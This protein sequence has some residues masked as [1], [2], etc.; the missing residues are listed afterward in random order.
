MPDCLPS[1]RRRYAAPSPNPARGAAGGAAPAGLEDWRREDP[2]PT[3]DRE[4]FRRLLADC[5]VES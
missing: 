2:E 1:G 4:R 3:D 5:L